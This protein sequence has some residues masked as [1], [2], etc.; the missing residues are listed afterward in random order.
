M[1]VLLVGPADARAELIAKFKKDRVY[2]SGACRVTHSGT[3]ATT[4]SCASG[5]A[6]LRGFLIENAPAAT[7]LWGVEYAHPPAQD[8]HLC[9]AECAVMQCPTPGGPPKLC[10]PVAPHTQT[11]P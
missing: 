11:C 8:D 6:A 7:I 4:I 9:A 3:E 1:N 5:Y 2:Q 10:C